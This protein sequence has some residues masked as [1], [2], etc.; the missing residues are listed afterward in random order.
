VKPP[1]P[2][3]GGKQTLA[4]QIVDLFP[5]HEH[6]VEPYAGGL[7]V[8]MAKSPSPIETVNDLDGA[9]VTFWRVL[10][11][12]E[13]ELARA[14]E[15][16]PH[17]RAEHD[18]ARDLLADDDV[19]TARR[20]WVRLT[21]GRGSNLGDERTGWRYAASPGY[22]SFPRHLDGYRSRIPPCAQRLAL[23]SL[24]CRPA[25]EVIAD[26]GRHSGVLLYVDPPYVVETRTRGG[27]Y[28]HEMTD[29]DH[30]V[31]GSALHAT[32]AAVVLSGYPSPLYDDLYGSWHRLDLDGQTSQGGA[33]RTTTEVLWS[34]RPL[35]VPLTLFAAREA[36]C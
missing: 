32:A 3:Y 28:T 1:F 8:L 10:R 19:E 17:A 15:L 5:D 34:N 27:K 16:T 22:G 7:S 29:A 4:A 30:A 2:Y 11:D 14:V 9:L 18:A 6:Y 21:Q 25:V 23:V 24:E 26:Y 35:G 31:L 36:S 12:R 13:A 20:V 33:G